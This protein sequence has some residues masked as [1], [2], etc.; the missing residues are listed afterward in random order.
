MEQKIQIKQKPHTVS[1]DSRASA[2][3]SGITEVLSYDDNSV[4]AACD[5]GDIE[6]SGSNLKIK[7][8]DVSDGLMTVEGGIDSVRYLSSSSKKS[9]FFERFFK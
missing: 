2:R 4:L 8:F 9:G 6:I 7:S 5:Y 1:I 3:V